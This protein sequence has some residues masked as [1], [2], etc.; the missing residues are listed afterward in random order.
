MND[1][2]KKININI[3]SCIF[4]GALSVIFFV[5]SLS[6][7]T[8]ESAL[9]PRVLCGITLA[10][11]VLYFIQ[12]LQ[13]KHNEELDFS[14]TMRAVQLGV[15]L[16]GYLLLNY[17]LGYYVATLIFMPVC[18]YHLG[19]RNWKVIAGVTIGLPLLAWLALD[20]LMEMQMPAPL[21]F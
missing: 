13:G 19:Q 14:G 7:E 21:L 4:V 12:I 17:L 10:L 16:S 8:P 20:L 3:L 9:F 15:I 1:V 2:K 18:M 6:I 11:S 5:A